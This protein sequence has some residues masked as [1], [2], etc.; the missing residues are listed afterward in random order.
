MPTYQEIRADFER[1]VR[2]AEQHIE[3]PFR[4]A[5]DAA[6]QTPAQQPVNLATAPAAAATQQGDTMAIVQLED[7][8]KK[9]LTDGMDWLDGLVQR[10]KAAAP[11][12]IATSEALGNS[13]LGKLAETA[14]GKF[15]PPG[16]EEEFLAL[17]GR[18]FGTFGQP[19]TAAAAAPAAPP[20]A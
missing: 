10:V 17:A 15:L 8:V 12:I 7:D 13:T 16:V 9:D 3:H 4:H 6:P 18:Y 1:G 19:V 5:A 2:T 11:G 20:V 14:A